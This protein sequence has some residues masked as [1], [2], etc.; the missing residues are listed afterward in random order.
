MIFPPE[1]VTRVERCR[2]EGR[3]VFWG[4]LFSFDVLTSVCVF[5]F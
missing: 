3:L 2:Q 4:M 1:V 5:I